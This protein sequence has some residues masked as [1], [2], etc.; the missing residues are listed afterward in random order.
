MIILKICTWVGAGVLL[1]VAIELIAEAVKYARRPKPNY[2]EE[3]DRLLELEDWEKQMYHDQM[4][5][6][7]S[8]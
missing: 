5:E 2:N 1:Y 3:V 6:N 7:L 8:A 4:K